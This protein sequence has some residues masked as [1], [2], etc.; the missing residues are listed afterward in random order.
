MGPAHVNTNESYSNNTTGSRM[1]I[2]WGGGD[3]IPSNPRNVSVAQGTAP[4]TRKIR[5]TQS[6]QRT[7]IEDQVN[8]PRLE[9]AKHRPPG[10]VGAT[11]LDVIDRCHVIQDTKSTPLTNQSSNDG[12]PF[13][14]SIQVLPRNVLL[15]RGD[16]QSLPGSPRLRTLPF[17]PSLLPGLLLSCG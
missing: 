4:S 6:E 10:S 11:R 3:S 12:I 7:H 5:H 14:R 8:L 2:F 9:R 16:V 17:S 1:G 13:V 15:Q